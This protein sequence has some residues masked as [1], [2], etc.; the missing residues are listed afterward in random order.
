MTDAPPTIPEINSQQPTPPNPIGEVILRAEHITKVFPGTIALDDVDFNTYQGKVNVLVGENGAGKST[1]MKILFGLEHPEEGSIYING[2][3]VNI[4]SPSAAIKNGIGMVHQHFMLVPSLT[5]A[6]NMVLGAEPQKSGFI[7]FN[8]AIS[9][10]EELSK[11]YNLSVD[12]KAVVADLP[13][14]MKQK[15]EILKA[16]LVSRL[17]LYIQATPYTYYVKTLDIN[18]IIIR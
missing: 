12:P 14:G 3:K 10:T 4:T 17:L 18:V 11:K 15:I 1:L 2:S 16:L 5:V 13:V 9:I 8:R 7:D 6:E